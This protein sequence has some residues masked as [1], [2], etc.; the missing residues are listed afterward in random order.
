MHGQR[1]DDLAIDSLVPSTVRT[2]L[3][4][5]EI[6]NLR[7]LCSEVQTRISTALLEAHNEELAASLADSES[8]ALALAAEASTAEIWFDVRKS[9]ETAGRLAES[10]RKDTRARSAVESGSTEDLRLELA[11][12]IA[13]LAVVFLALRAPEGGPDGEVCMDAAANP[14]ADERRAS[15]SAGQDEAHVEMQEMHLR[16][17]TAVAEEMRQVEIADMSE[18]QV[19]MLR[20]EV[21]AEA[22]MAEAAHSSCFF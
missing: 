3:R 1:L 18:A 12:V 15:S 7:L 22:Q 2:A 10:L 14:R 8:A 4:P 9:E 11:T 19:A 21:D 17:S 6:E 16:L 13:E 20:H 5:A